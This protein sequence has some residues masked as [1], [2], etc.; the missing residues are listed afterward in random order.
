[1]RPRI[2]RPWQAL[3]DLRNEAAAVLDLPLMSLQDY[4][5]EIPVKESGISVL[6]PNRIS[7]F[8]AGIILAELRRYD[9]AISGGRPKLCNGN[10]RRSSHTPAMPALVT[11]R[12]C[13]R[14]TCFKHLLD[15]MTHAVEALLVLGCDGAADRHPNRRSSSQAN[16]GKGIGRWHI[17]HQKSKPR[18]KAANAPGSEEYHHQLFRLLRAAQTYST[19]R[20]VDEARTKLGWY[21]TTFEGEDDELAESPKVSPNKKK[22]E[23]SWPKNRHAE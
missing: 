9:I 2:S 3:L 22:R 12:D 18:L 6:R 4:A 5:N 15:S 1:M 19:F 13:H 17:W 8:K 14:T 20:P 16:R 10:A 23:S 21:D 7:L 11:C